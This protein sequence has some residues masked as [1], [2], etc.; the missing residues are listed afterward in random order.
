M[1]KLH[2]NVAAELPD[3]LKNSVS[4]SSRPFVVIKKGYMDLLE[5]FWAKDRYGGTEIFPA[6]TTVKVEAT[7]IVLTR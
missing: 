7:S 3:Y 4:S 1:H 2:F 6:W 5:G